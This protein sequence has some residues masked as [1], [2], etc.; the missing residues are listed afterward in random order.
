M[1]GSRGVIGHRPL[2]GVLL[3]AAVLLPGCIVEREPP[4]PPAPPAEP[5][6]FVVPTVPGPAPFTP[7]VDVKG[8]D[9]VEPVP[10]AGPY[11]GTGSDLVCDRELLISSLLA[12]PDRLQEWARVARVAP[13]PEAV[14]AYVRDLRPA[15]LC[16]DT[17]VTNH[18]FVGG[19]AVPYQAVLTAGTAVLV[20]SSGR[21]VARCRCGNPLREAVTAPRVECVD[22]PPGYRLPPPPNPGETGAPGLPDPAADGQRGGTAGAA[23]LGARRDPLPG[24]QRGAV[25]LH[26]SA[27]RHQRH[28]VGHGDLHRR[29]VHLLGRG[30]L[31]QQ[32]AT[33][34]GGGTVTIEIREG[35][36]SYSGTSRNGVTS[37]DY[38]TWPGSFV[39]VR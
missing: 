20:D 19:R 11:G 7:A 27:R 29:L 17:R 15:T 28:R 23:E 10:G 4:P 33:P 8:Q 14:S 26:L 3:A 9:R 13:S 30:A 25:H 34:A 21:P 6:R 31:G 2:A 35:R 5:V 38:G 36:E 39:V 22:C 12:R 37:L 1:R 24:T 16:R 32:L 18:S